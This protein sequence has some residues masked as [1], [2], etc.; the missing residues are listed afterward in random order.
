MSCSYYSSFQ[1]WCAFPSETSIFN[2]GGILTSWSCHN[3]LLRLHIYHLS[4]KMLCWWRHG[5]SYDCIGL[6][7]LTATNVLKTL[8]PDAAVLF[9]FIRA[10]FTPVASL[11]FY[12]PLSNLRCKYRFRCNRSLASSS[13]L[14]MS[15]SI[16]NMPFFQTSIFPDVLEE[17]IRSYACP[18]TGEPFPIRKDLCNPLIRRLLFP[19]TCHRDDPTMSSPEQSFIRNRRLPM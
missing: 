15:M 16:T 13:N 4:A 9:S 10:P 5:I 11:R 14:S 6:T 2:W 19:V 17:K 12:S 7:V 1:Y 18:L 8:Y 3:I